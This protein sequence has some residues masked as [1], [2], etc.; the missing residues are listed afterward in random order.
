MVGNAALQAWMAPMKIR[1]ELLLDKI[2]RHILDR[3]HASEAGIIDQ[4]VQAP[5]AL[6]GCLNNIACVSSIG[7][8]QPLCEQLVGKL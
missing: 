3:T 5:K 7:H 4:N 6:D 2:K 8:F 1:V